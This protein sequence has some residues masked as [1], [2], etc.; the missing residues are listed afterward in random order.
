MANEIRYKED[1]PVTATITLASLANGS[2]RQCTAIANASKRPTARVSGKITTGTSPTAGTLISFYR[3][4][5]NGTYR[6]DGAGAAD[7]AITI[8]NAE[9]VETLVVDATSNKEYDFSFVVGDWGDPLSSEFLV[10]VSNGTGV[11]LHAT[12]GNHA[13]VVEFGLPEVQ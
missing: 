10:A 3:I 9:L 8:A 2:A 1:A 12:T 7:A 5:T 4:R 6:Q 13:M 11:A